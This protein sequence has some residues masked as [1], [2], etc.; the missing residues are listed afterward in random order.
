MLMPKRVKYRKQMRGTSKGVEIRAVSLAFGSYGLK[1]YGTKWISSRQLEAARRSIL[2]YLKKGGR[3]W[4]RLFPDKP[5]TSKG[6]EVP[7]GG[8]KGDVDH[9]VYPIRPGRIIFEMDGV[10]EE[11]AREALHEAAGKLPVHT[12]FIK[13]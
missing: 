6:S 7:M 9:Y 13:R 12:K 8:G 1:A 2:R 10:S 4:L 5:I 11:V 3:I